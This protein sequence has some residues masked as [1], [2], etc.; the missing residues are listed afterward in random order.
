[1]C[2]NFVCWRT[3]KITCK[4]Y[5]FCT[6]TMI[7][8]APSIHLPSLSLFVLLSFAQKIHICSNRS[9][10]LLRDIFVE[11]SF[12]CEGARG[13]TLTKLGRCCTQI[14]LKHL[15]TQLR[16]QLHPSDLNPSRHSCTNT[17][18]EFATHPPSRTDL[19]ESPSTDGSKSSGM[20]H[21]HTPKRF[22]IHVIVSPVYTVYID[23]FGECQPIE[24]LIRG[25]PGAFTGPY[26]LY[27][28]LN[29]TIA[30]TQEVHV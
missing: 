3:L 17:L 10:P 15:N 11:L 5:T 7:R 21:L 4:Q 23:K 20:L 30:I 19:C 2:S 25:Q 24:A 28:C 1:M 29:Y 13:P 14:P 9:P 16:T 12:C 26:V 22:F 8:T 18:F 27:L 6:E